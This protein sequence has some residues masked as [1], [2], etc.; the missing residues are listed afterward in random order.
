[1]EDNAFNETEA[2]PLVLSSINNK[3]TQAAPAV[4]K[5]I[6]KYGC[7]RVFLTDKPDS[8]TIIRSP[9]ILLS[10]L[11]RLLDSYS[12]CCPDTLFAI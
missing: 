9:H 2:I 8:L 1:M 4:Q 12:Q 10:C 11:G 3:H 6:Q 7:L 5:L